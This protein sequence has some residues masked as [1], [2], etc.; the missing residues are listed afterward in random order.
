MGG[1]VQAPP[2]LPGLCDMTSATHSDVIISS[3]SSL[4]Y[5]TKTPETVDPN[6]CP[7]LKF[8]LSGHS[9]VKVTNMFSS[10]TVFPKYCA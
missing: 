8:F 9:S 6:K 4:P 2:L 3:L 7:S 5:W 1:G 10:P